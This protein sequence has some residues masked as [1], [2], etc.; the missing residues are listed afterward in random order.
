MWVAL[1]TLP[2]GFSWSLYYCHSVVCNVMVRSLGV[3]GLSLAE[4]RQ[5]IVRD[6]EPSPRLG[7]GRPV[8][9]P[10]VDNALFLC[11]NLEDALLASSSLQS[12]LR[13]FGLRFRV[14]AEGVDSWTTVGLSFNATERQLCGRPERPS[15]S[16]AARTLLRSRITNHCWSLYLVIHAFSPGTLHLLDSLQVRRAL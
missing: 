5:Q 12:V 6:K 10:Y 4:A 16:A 8:A 1:T 11:W 15:C 9:A 3:F 7:R 13:G 2:M 14:E